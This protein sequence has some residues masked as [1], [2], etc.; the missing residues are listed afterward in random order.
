MKAKFTFVSV[1]IP[2]YKAAA[3]IRRAV[4]SVVSQ[5]MRPAEVILVDD[6]SGDGTLDA[7]K[8]IKREYGDWI[9]IVELLSNSGAA[10]ARNAGWEV[11]TQ[12]FVAFLD[13]DDTWHPEKIRIQYDFM[14]LNPDVALS[15][16]QC[17]LFTGQYEICPRHPL[18]NR[19]IRPS[20]MLFRNP[21]STPTVMLKREVPFRFSNNLRYAEDFNL[22]L[23]VGF[24]GLKIVRLEWPLAFVHKPFYGAGGLSSHLWKMEVGELRNFYLLLQDKKISFSMCVMAQIFSLLKFMKRLM[25]AQLRMAF[26]RT[27]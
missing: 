15:G 17:V 16:H 13:A 7:I 19:P 1:V 25:I 9:R 6:A 18:E 10:A 5:T 21:F 4:A 8:E 3:V 26:G 23:N 27:G 2:C 24:S 14:H 20:N 11:A 22:W 12:P